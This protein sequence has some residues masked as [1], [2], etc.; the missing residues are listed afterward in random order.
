MFIISSQ[1]VRDL[2][3]QPCMERHLMFMSGDRSSKPHS[4]QNESNSTTLE[5]KQKG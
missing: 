2:K 5:H 3:L 4:N 1:S